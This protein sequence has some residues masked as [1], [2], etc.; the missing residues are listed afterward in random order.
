MNRSARLIIE[1]SLSPTL[2]TSKNQHLHPLFEQQSSR[3]A[4][5]ENLFTLN[6]TFLLYHTRFNTMNSFENLKVDLFN[7]NLKN[8]TP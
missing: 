6:T 8:L 4:Q 3:C 7:P 5:I 2:N 1:F